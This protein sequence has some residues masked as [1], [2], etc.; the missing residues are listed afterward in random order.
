MEDILVAIVGAGPS[1]LATAACLN[2]MLIPNIILEREDCCASLWKKRAYDRLKLHLAKRYCALPLLPHLPTTPKYMS[3]DTFV[4][5]L[6]DYAS[7]FNIK[8]LYNRSVE[9]SFYDENEKKWRIEAKNT[10]SGEMEV[11]AAKFLV[12]ATGENSQAYVPE[13]PGLESFEGE[14]VHASEYKSGL[15]YGGKKVLVVGCGNSGMEISRDLSDFGAHTSILI[16]SP[17]HVLTRDMVFLGMKLL[18]YLPVKT[19]DSMLL[20]MA[21]LV[22]GNLS[23]CGIH[24]P[25]QGPFAFKAATGKTPVI[26]RGAVEKIQ[27]GEI[28]VVPDI[29]NI[30]GST[31]E[32][33]N[34]V[35]KSFDAIIFAT[36]YK[37]V[38]YNWL[39]DYQHVLEADGLPKYKY[40]NLWRGEKRLYCAGMLGKGLAGVSS[41]AKSIAHDIAKIINAKR[42][43][44]SSR[45]GPQGKVFANAFIS[46]FRRLWF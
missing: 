21:K 42:K 12:V 44:R 31:V 9:H 43:M 38:A 25:K 32:F 6:D 14:I 34:G 8:P 10:V 29:V 33:K 28:E 15:T 3:K 37:S 11:Y 26:D 41:D 36:G 24:R 35:H 27:A 40:P 4:C 18:Q 30:D 2:S 13:V 46:K 16:R 23:K 39:Q 5:Y 19:V 17:F 20:T 1:G 45:K 7:R 22:F